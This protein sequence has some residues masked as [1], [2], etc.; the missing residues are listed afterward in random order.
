MALAQSAFAAPPAPA[1]IAPTGAAMG[2]LTALSLSHMCNDMVQSVAQAMYPTFRDLYG[3]SFLQLGL[4]TLAFQGTASVLQPLVG[5]WTDRRPMPLALPS[6]MAATFIGIVAFALTRGY[7][8]LVVSVAIIGIGSAIFH[9]EASRAARSASGGR[10]GLAQSLFQL[11]GNFGQAIGPLLVALIV[12][13][14]GQTSALLFAGFALIAMVL[15]ARVSR[16]RV[17]RMAAQAAQPKKATPVNAL[18]R[19]VVLRSLAILMLLVF[20]KVS[21]LSGLGTY[22]AVYL[23][24]NFSLSN[25]QAQLL[26]F[27]FLLAVAAGTFIGGPVG[28]RYGRKFVIW[29]SIVGVLPFTM[30]MPY[31][32]LAGTVIDTVCIGL[33]LASAFSAIVV[34]AQELAPGN[35]GVIAG[36]FF[37]LSFGLGGVAA[38]VLGW[39]A[40]MTSLRLVYQMT[41]FLPFIGLLTVFLPNVRAKPL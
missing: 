22:Y 8:L 21:Y 28:D 19:P 31:L 3:L 24:D 7:P 40:D 41:A 10:H 26:L 12:T 1:T 17:A 35:V 13:P 16:W 36:L 25:Q 34:Y 38:A 37:G 2:I 29:A 18:P 33:V 32:G 30:A 4:V 6:A 15:L 23:K 20:S 39:I 5:Y 11:G 9:P 27:V 14:L